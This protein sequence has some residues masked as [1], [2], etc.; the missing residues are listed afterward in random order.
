MDIERAKELL[1]TL[2]DGIDPMTGEVLGK[3]DSCNQV[4]IVRALH[5]V[6]HEL[7]K[8]PKKKDKKPA[9][10]RRKALDPGRR[11]RALQNVRL[12]RNKE[13][14]LRALQAHARRDSVKARAT[15]QAP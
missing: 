7:D 11:S 13:G 5:T 10:E 15:R 9:R 4:E 8:L 1:S 2:A 12:R 3:Y 14:A 6:L